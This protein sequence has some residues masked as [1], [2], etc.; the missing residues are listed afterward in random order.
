MNKHSDRG[1][2]T[3]LCCLLAV[4]TCTK[5]LTGF[6]A[7]SIYTA[8]IAGA[9]LG[10][11]HLCLRPLIRLATAP[12]GCLTLGL[13][14]PLIDIGLIYACDRLVNGFSVNDPFHALLAV[15]LINTITFIAAGRR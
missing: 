8:L 7:Q 13:V 2:I 14:Q 6:H 5:L 11:A 12:I 15:V 10:A 9:L 3:F 1:A 4:P